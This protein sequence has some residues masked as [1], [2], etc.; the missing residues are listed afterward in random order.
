MG[1]VSKRSR[2]MPSGISREY[3][4]NVDHI[5]AQPIDGFGAEA[6][7]PRDPAATRS[8]S[9]LRSNWQL[10]DLRLPHSHRRCAFS[11]SHC[12]LSFHL[13]A[14]ARLRS[15]LVQPATVPVV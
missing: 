5:A 2:A 14:A 8:R 1:S 6:P 4:D 10:A 11:F 13:S 7:R 3:D 15:E 12:E 9:R